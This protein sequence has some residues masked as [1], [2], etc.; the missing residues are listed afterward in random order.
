MEEYYF[1]LGLGLIWTIFAVVCD[2]KKREVPNWL[3]FSLV[4]FGLA[5]RAFYSL[6]VNDARFFVYGLIGFGIFFA[7]A[8]GFYYAK[9]FAGGDA[10]L[11]MG[12]GVIL[13]YD[14]FF[15]LFYF[16]VVFLFSLFFLGAIYSLVYSI[17]V[18]IKREERFFG[19]FKK[20]LKGMYALLFVIL[21][22]FV[23][24]LFFDSF[25]SL[26]V[27][28][29]FVLSVLYVY[30]K[31]LDKCMVVNVS[32]EKLQEGDWII[33][34][35]KVGGQ[36]VKKSVHGLGKKDIELLRRYKKSVDV[37][38]GIPFTPAFLLALI[39]VF[40]FLVLDVP[41]RIFSLF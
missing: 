17:S 31:A 14:N 26:F 24:S 3:N 13:P 34:D 19:E 10:K 22:L 18:V 37:K 4:G 25:Y 9:A 8:Y 2:L 6:F 21:I 33:G 27:L 1:L 39:T 32:Y 11:L 40:S 5:Y 12:F 28:G 23:L 20:G 7:L 30:L 41:L 36:I 38:E 16:G 29:F 15:S 35:I